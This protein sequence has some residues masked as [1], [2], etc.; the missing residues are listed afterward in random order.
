MAYWTRTSVVAALLVG[1]ALIPVAQAQHHRGY[2]Q[3]RHHSDDTG[4]IVGTII[5]LGILGMAIG[6]ANQPSGYYTPPPVYYPYSGYPTPPPPAVY[7]GTPYG[8]PAPS[9]S[10]PWGRY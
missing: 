4:A 3:R 5:G 6:A 9:Y 2:D 7:Y 10:Y 1:L 8:T